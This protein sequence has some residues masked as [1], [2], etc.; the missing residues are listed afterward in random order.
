MSIAKI[1]LITLIL[2]ISSCSHTRVVNKDRCEFTKAS[3]DIGSG[4]TKIVV[5]DVDMCKGEIVNVLYEASRAIPL[6]NHLIHNKNSFAKSF[7]Y[8][9]I[10]QIEQLKNIAQL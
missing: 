3:F 8:D 5:A 1:Y 10:D 7:I 9:S 6:K 2:F 4:S